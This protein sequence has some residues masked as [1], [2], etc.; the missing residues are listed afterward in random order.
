MAEPARSSAQRKADVLNH[1]ENDK[2]LW[3]ASS[4]SQGV[5]CLVPLSFWWDGERLFLATAKTNPTARNIE[6][7]GCARV[8]LGHTRD[9]VLINGAIGSLLEES[10]KDIGDAYAAKCGWDPRETETYGF[11][12]FEPRRV[13]SWRELNEH[14][15]RLLMRDGEWL[16]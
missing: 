1:L 10:L 6:S 8:A 5:P 12:V 13:E 14:A 15:D 3:I 7:T 11:F 4:D 16:V 9:V 2:D